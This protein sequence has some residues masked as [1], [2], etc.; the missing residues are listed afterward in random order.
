[1]GVDLAHQKNKMDGQVNFIGVH[2]G[3]PPKTKLPTAPET[4]AFNKSYQ[5]ASGTMNSL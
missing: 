2:F 4:K 1:M 5:D 3:V